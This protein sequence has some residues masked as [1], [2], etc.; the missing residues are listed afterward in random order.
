MHALVKHPPPAFHF[1]LFILPPYF[2]TLHLFLLSLFPRLVRRL[3]RSVFVS[4]PQ[5]F[6]KITHLLHPPHPAV[7]FPDSGDPL[8]SG[9]EPARPPSPSS[10]SAR[11]LYLRCCRNRATRLTNTTLCL[12]VVRTTD[13]CASLAVRHFNY[14]S[15]SRHAS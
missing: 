7:S 8:R 14:L 13:V 15:C 4:A 5:R 6:N 11:E 3:R 9:A 10:L 12:S 2:Q 1:F